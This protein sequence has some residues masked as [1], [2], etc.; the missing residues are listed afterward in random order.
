MRNKLGIFG[1][2]YREIYISEELYNNF[3]SCKVDQ[4]GI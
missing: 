1:Y 3:Q 2:Y 4:P